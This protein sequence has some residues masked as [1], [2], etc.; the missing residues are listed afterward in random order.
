[1]W[2]TSLSKSCAVSKIFWFSSLMNR[3]VDLAFIFSLRLRAYNTFVSLVTCVLVNC[4]VIVLIVILVHIEYEEIPCYI[5][6]G[7]VKGIQQFAGV[8]IY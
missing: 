3:R 5:I 8:N 6:K 4:I 2:I 7:C 1:M